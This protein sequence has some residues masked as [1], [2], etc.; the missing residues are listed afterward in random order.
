MRVDSATDKKLQVKQV[1][2]ITFFKK[3][4][5]YFFFG[6]PKVAIKPKI[7]LR[8]QAAASFGEKEHGFQTEY[9]YNSQK[10]ISFPGKN[11]KK[12]LH[13]KFQDRPILQHR[14]CRES[15]VKG[16]I[17]LQNKKIYRL[18]GDG[19]AEIYLSNAR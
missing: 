3:K 1:N 11:A 14:T 17:E 12:I 8:F 7:N 19:N 18:A 15:L 5:F 2:V 10:H 4:F 9:R 13:G 6:K 16:K